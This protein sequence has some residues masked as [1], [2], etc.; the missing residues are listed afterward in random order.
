MEFMS[1]SIFKAAVEGDTNVLDPESEQG[2]SLLLKTPDQ[3][4]N[5]IHIAVRYG[6]LNF[7]SK[8][9]SLFHDLLEQ[10]NNK[11]NT[12]LH[13]AAALAT[14]KT[15]QRLLLLL[16][17]STTSTDTTNINSNSSINNSSDDA[18]YLW[19]VNDQGDTPFHVALRSGNVEAAEELFVYVK[20]HPDILVLETFSHK[21]TPLHLYVR[22]CAGWNLPEKEEYDD[23]GNKASRPKFIYQLIEANVLAMFKVDSEGLNPLMRAAQ[24][25]RVVLIHGM[26]LRYP[27]SMECQDSKGKTFLHHL[28]LKINVRDRECTLFACKNILQLPGVDI[29]SISRDQDGNTPVHLAILDKDYDLAQLILERYVESQSTARKQLIMNTMNSEGK[30][31]Y[32]L[33]T[34]EPGIP[35]ILAWFKRLKA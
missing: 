3:G 5:V 18:P 14:R 28:R 9:N 1:S 22:Y 25:G 4:N 7:I 13:E 23:N 35:S 16:S 33:N 11:G 15:V 26:L 10:K 6:R 20:H 2:G 30:T 12:P 19:V 27:Q 31:V 32:D 24:C 21:E 8:A 29:L 17:S 34:S